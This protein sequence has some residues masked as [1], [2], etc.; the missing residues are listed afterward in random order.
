WLTVVGVASNI[1]Q[2]PTRQV[3]DPLVYV[4]YRQRATSSMWVFV[5]AGVAS[6]GLGSAFRREVQALDSNLPIWIGP[7][8]LSERLAAIY[9]NRGLYGVLFLIFAAIALLLASIGLYAVVAHS[10]SQR[11]R[12]IGIRT[13]LGATARDVL[14]LVFRRGMTPVG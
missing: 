2:N 8:T 11:T 10:V 3:F 12:E 14:T 5:R 13:A 7:F 1:V 6:A 4:P 9:W